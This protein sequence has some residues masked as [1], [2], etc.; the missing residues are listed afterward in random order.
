MGR[1]D[2][3]D[4]GVSGTYVFQDVWKDAGVGFGLRAYRSNQGLDFNLLVS[5]RLLCSWIGRVIALK[6]CCPKL[7]PQPVGVRC[8]C[9]YACADGGL[10]V[11]SFVFLCN[12]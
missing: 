9:V 7:S 4:D 10:G 12:N 6:R 3:H 11:V 8:G 1:W 2:R 5:H